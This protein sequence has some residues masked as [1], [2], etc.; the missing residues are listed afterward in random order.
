MSNEK[1]PYFYLSH[2][3]MTL[4]IIAQIATFFSL[5]YFIV[6][7]YRASTSMKP[8]APIEL[9]LASKPAPVLKKIGMALI[10]G[11]GLAIFICWKTGYYSKG[12]VQFVS[13]AALIGVAIVHDP[14]RWLYEAYYY[15]NH[16]KDWARVK[17]LAINELKTNYWKIV[18]WRFVL[19]VL[20]LALVFWLA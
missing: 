15:N 7:R 20:I 14:E 5:G 2:G 13:L 4:D 18:F 10:A 1:E 8:P 12:I 6:S 16:P 19:V 11:V 3:P 17:K 9:W